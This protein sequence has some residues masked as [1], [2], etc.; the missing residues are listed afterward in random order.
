MAETT[1]VTSLSEE[2]RQAIRDDGRT[3]TELARHCGVDPPRLSRFVRGQRL[4][5][6]PAVDAI[7]RE[8]GARLVRPVR[9][10]DEPPRRRKG[11]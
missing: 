9:P 4:L 5:T 2:L 7:A 1:Q 11:K 3:L 10:A 8:L 6:L